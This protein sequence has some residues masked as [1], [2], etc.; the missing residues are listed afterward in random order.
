MKKSKD[1]HSVIL[2]AL[3]VRM[4][5]VIVAGGMLHDEEPAGLQQLLPEDELRH[6]IHISERIGR[7]CKDEVEL[8]GALLQVLKHVATDDLQPVL[9][10]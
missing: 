4:L 1:G 5:L 8:I 10:M 9:Y 6:L 2:H 7:I 3:K